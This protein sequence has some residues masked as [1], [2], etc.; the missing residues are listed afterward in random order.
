MKLS[1]YVFQFIKK[2]VA[3][4][5]FLISGGHIMHLVDS[6]GKSGLNVYCCHHEQGVVTAADGYAR[7]NNKIGVACVTL[8]GVPNAVTGVVGAWLDSIPVL[9]ISGQVRKDHMVPRKAGMPII[10]QIGFQE[11]DAVN[12]VKPI[13]KYMVSVEA[14]EDI[15][16][17]LE[18]AVYLATHGRPGPVWIEIPLDIQEAEIEPDGLRSFDSAEL[19]EKKSVLEPALMEKIAQLLKEAKKPLFLAGNGIRMAGG[20]EILRKVLEKLKINVVTPIFTA[21]DLV[22][23]DYPFYL[24]RQGMPGNKTANYAIDNCDVLLVVGERLQLTQTSWDYDKFA[25]QAK[26]IMVDVDEQELYKKT[27]KIDVPVHCDAKLFLENLYK[28]E[29]QLNRWEIKVEPINPD[30]YAGDKKYLNVY[31]FLNKLSNCSKGIDV[32]TANGMASVASHQALRISSGQRFITNAGLGNM[33]SGLPMAIGACIAREK[34]PIICL[35]GDGSIMMNIQELQ[36]VVHHKLPIKI[37]IFN[38]NGYYSIRSTHLK[39]FN[40]I[41]AS[42]PATGVSFPDFSRLIP[43]WGLAY[44]RI[45]NDDELSKVEKVM[46][47]KGPIVCELMLDPDQPMLERWS[48]GI[49]NGK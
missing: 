11:V 30:N 45:N 23:Y 9:V 10:R 7:I 6:L 12:L 8:P 43:A 32:A 46:E 35:E 22:T 48:A 5:V 16:Y 4:S 28:Q 39:F 38:N 42:D 49:L 37:F 34:K 25:A 15:R 33:G 17:Y 21:D 18:K 31:S 3:D 27:I 40:K 26:K 41:F 44:E 29:I 1:D 20:E 47:H 14:K 13:T 2:Q 36:T 24:G 19:E